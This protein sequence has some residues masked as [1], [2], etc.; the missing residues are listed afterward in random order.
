[1]KNPRR[2]AGESAWP[3]KQRA[4]FRRCPALSFAGFDVIGC[5]Y[6][7]IQ[8][9]GGFRPTFAENEKKNAHPE[10]A[11]ENT[12]INRFLKNRRSWFVGRLDGILSLR[13]SFAVL[14]HVWDTKLDGW[15]EAQSRSIRKPRLSGDRRAMFDRSTGFDN[16]TGRPHRCGS[17]CACAVQAD[18]HR[19]Y[20][21]S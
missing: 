9:A 18:S 14:P 19:N 17:V 16:T 11:G 15:L 8:H 10:M 6:L 5:V 20:R 21:S 13:Q 7:V 3:L 1:M 2:Q 12:Q 4:K